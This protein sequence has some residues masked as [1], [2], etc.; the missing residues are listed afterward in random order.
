MKADIIATVIHPTFEEIAIL[1]GIVVSRTVIS[2]FVE[3]E[4]NKLT[5]MDKLKEN[6]T[7]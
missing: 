2:F 7:E 4:I 1:A 3:K 5:T 6:N